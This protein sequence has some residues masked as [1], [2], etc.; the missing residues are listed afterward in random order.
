MKKKSKLLE[1]NVTGKLT[2]TDFIHM[3]QQCADEIVQIDAQ[4]QEMEQQ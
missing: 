4:L 3:N 2:D 1:Y